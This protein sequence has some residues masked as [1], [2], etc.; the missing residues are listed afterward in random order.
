M[1]VLRCF[2]DSMEYR[3]TVTTELYQ[4][5]DRLLRDHGIDI[6]FP[7]R[8]IHLAARGPLDI[9]LH[10]ARS[11]DRDPGSAEA[12]PGTEPRG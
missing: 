1:M 8:D 9:R 3:T 7:Q 5:I 12:Q 6:A 4:A 2:L 10:R 11:A